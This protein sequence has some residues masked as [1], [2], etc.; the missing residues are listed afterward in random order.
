MLN[1]GSLSAKAVCTLAFFATKA[2]AQGFVKRLSFNPDAASGHFQRHIDSVLLFSEDKKKLYE[3]TCPGH[4]RYDKD[5]VTHTIHT[6][7]LHEA[8]ANEVADHPEMASTL[9]AMTE[10]REW[11]VDAY[12]HP[13]VRANPGDDVYPLSLYLDGISHTKVDN[14]LGIT[15]S[16]LVSGNRHLCVVLR[17]TILCRC[18]CRGWCTMREIWVFIHW[19]LVQLANGEFPSERHDAK[20]WLPSD[21]LREPLQGIV[22]G[23]KEL[24]SK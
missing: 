7:P 10:N 17:K 20:S 24:W 21:E 11:S 1:R 16:S 4:T 22:G 18:G 13:V 14:V 23:S 6:V 8:L 15:I 12:S 9:K 19:P 5:R 3:L 2:G